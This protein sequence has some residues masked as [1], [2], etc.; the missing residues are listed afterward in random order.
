M[1]TKTALVTGISGQ[2]G[3]YLAR[4]LLEKGYRVLGAVRRSSSSRL[5][6]LTELGIEGEVELVYFELGELT[7][8]LRLLERQKPDEIYNLA[9]QSFVGVS[10]E[11]PLYTV[12]V[13]GLGVMRLLEGIRTHCSSA[14]FYQASTSEMFGKARAVPQ[15]EQT[16][17]YPRSPY[18]IAKVTA[19]WATVNYRESF[20]LHASSGI[21][22]NHE[23]PL[24][25]T[26]FVTRK[27]TL[28][29][30]RILAGKQD[31]IELGNL[32]SRRDWGYAGDYVEGMWRMTQ[33]DDAGDYVL[34]TGETR[35]IREF[36]GY[37]CEAAGVR[38]EWRGEGMLE[39]GNDARTGRTLVRINPSFLRP[40][41]VELL[42]GNPA[43]A[44]EKLGWTARVDVRTLA[45]MMYE[46]D[47]RRVRDGNIPF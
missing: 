9:A 14:R 39:T 12:D 44:K 29:L 19:H 45:Q 6:R 36:V 1:T 4:L 32:D 18:G 40:A 25:G 5:P 8:I 35:T 10:W 41:E 17:F 43:R 24:R 37:A 20:G 11:Q 23:S 42:I 2:D 15:D 30:A 13:G 21:L 31:P 27:I 3:A 7:Q 22:F 34:A 46:T 28:G 33:Q 47:A 38:I 16:P 26:E